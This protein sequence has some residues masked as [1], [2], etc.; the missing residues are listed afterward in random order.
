MRWFKLILSVVLVSCG[1]VQDS[2]WQ[3]YQK[4]Y[5]EKFENLST[6]A[7]VKTALDVELGAYHIA[8]HY[9]DEIPPSEG[10]RLVESDIEALK[11]MAAILVVAIRRYPVSFTQPK[12]IGL[13]G[14]LKVKGRLVGGTVSYKEMVLNVR[15]AI[16]NSSTEKTFHHEF[17]HYIEMQ[18]SNSLTAFDA[19]W[20]ALNPPGFKYVGSTDSF[21]DGWKNLAPKPGFISDY[22]ESL[23]AE[24]RAETYAH[25]MTPPY[26]QKLRERALTDSVLKKKADFIKQFIGTI[27]PEMDGKFFDAI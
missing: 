15:S 26:A 9:G 21:V 25:L 3:P 5:Q 1:G 8:F 13:L 11:K 23:P 10:E 22:A 17:F 27:S 6:L 19:E 24:D 2:V 14:A 12:E 16:L 20:N 7:Q 18:R 4:V